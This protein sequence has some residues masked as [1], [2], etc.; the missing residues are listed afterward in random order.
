MSAKYVTFDNEALSHMPV[1]DESSDLLKGLHRQ[2]HTIIHDE[3]Y[4]GSEEEEDDDDNEDQSFMNTLFSCTPGTPHLSPS[5]PASFKK[6]AA[7]LVR[8]APTVM[9]E[10]RSDMVMSMSIGSP[11]F[12]KKPNLFHGRINDKSQSTSQPQRLRG[13]SDDAPILKLKLPLFD[14][15][16]SDTSWLPKKSKKKSKK[17]EKSKTNQKINPKVL[18]K[19]QSSQVDEDDEEKFTNHPTIRKFRDQYSNWRKGSSKGSTGELTSDRLDGL[20]VGGEEFEVTD[21]IALPEQQIELIEKD[22]FAEK[23]LKDADDKHV[24]KIQNENEN[25]NFAVYDVVE[26]PPFLPNEK[27]SQ[28]DYDE[29]GYK[30]LKK[31]DTMT[32]INKKGEEVAIDGST[33]MQT[34]LNGVNAMCGLSLLSMPFVMYEI[35]IG[36]VPILLLICLWCIHTMDLLDQCQVRTGSVS[37]P[38]VAT[39]AFGSSGRWF[40]GFLCYFDL[41]AAAVGTMIVTASALDVVVFAFTG[42]QLGDAKSKLITA[43]AYIPTCFI[44][45]LTFVSYLSMGGL[46]ANLFTVTFVLVF[47][48]GLCILIGDGIDIDDIDDQNDSLDGSTSQFGDNNISWD[49]W[50]HALSIHIKSKTEYIGPNPFIPMSLIVYSFTMH[51]LFPSLRASMANPAQ[52]PQ[53]TR[54]VLWSLFVIIIIFSCSVYFI[55][56]SKVPEL[57][58]TEL[59]TTF[60]G[61]GANIM[62]LFNSYSKFPL[63]LFPVCDAVIELLPSSSSSSSLSEVEE[64]K[65]QNEQQQQI[66]KIEERDA[67]GNIKSNKVNSMKQLASVRMITVFAVLFTCVFVSGF[68]SIIGLCSWIFAPSLSLAIPLCC[69]LRIF[70]EE[71]NTFWRYLYQGIVIFSLFCS[72]AGT[73]MNVYYFT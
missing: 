22:F 54:I 18:E 57:I 70:G 40:T 7:L 21:E 53:M 11:E 38:D 73:I 27:E 72:V 61:L 50:L 1:Y 28:L 41:F 64:N 4:S 49:E 43:I 44:K 52:A 19:Q 13:Y 29:F 48:G 39:V 55:L 60:L 65:H 62:V 14:A 36:F 47:I 30:S 67:H 42:R 16:L 33:L 15:K 26:I 32:M 17:K 8:H 23:G 46:I 20:T 2:Y 59:G 66:K 69:Y 56:G 63:A 5:W 25:N 12:R 51:S 35:G 9:S 6:S 10:T 24:V 45:D 58:T 37:F 34:V 31:R 3:D 68:A 71:I